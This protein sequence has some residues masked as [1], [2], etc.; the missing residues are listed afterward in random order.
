MKNRQH[1]RPLRL[2][3]QCSTRFA[4]AA[5]HWH[6]PLARCRPSCR[7]HCPGSTGWAQPTPAAGRPLPACLRRS[8]T[9]CKCLGPRRLRQN[10]D[11]RHADAHQ[12]LMLWLADALWDPQTS[13]GLCRQHKCVVFSQIMHAPLTGWDSRSSNH[14]P[15]AGSADASAPQAAGGAAAAAGAA[16]RS[17]STHPQRAAG[18]GAST[19]R[20]AAPAGVPGEP[21]SGETRVYECLAMLQPGR[22]GRGRTA[23]S[24]WAMRRSV[25]VKGC[26]PQT[27][28]TRPR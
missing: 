11:R 15:L 13:A 21:D 4:G 26:R 1:I 2:M 19:G 6:R 28:D 7:S 14:T 20:A 10:Q 27:F 23:R 12:Q 24:E 17:A 25:P 9:G 5:H 8:K 22:S 16:E 3:S 18:R